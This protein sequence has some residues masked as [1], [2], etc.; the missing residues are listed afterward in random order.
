M[1]RVMMQAGTRIDRLDLVRPLA[2]QELAAEVFDV[3]SE[4]LQEVNGWAD[5]F[6][7]KIVE[8]G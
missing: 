4:M 2:S 3:S 6:R 1:A 5:L 7:I 8:P